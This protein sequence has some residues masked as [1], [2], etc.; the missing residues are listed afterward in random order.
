MVEFELRVLVGCEVNINNGN[1]SLRELT[2][3][4]APIFSIHRYYRELLPA[5][6]KY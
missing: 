4:T 2:H 5:V 1:N 6:N 3:N